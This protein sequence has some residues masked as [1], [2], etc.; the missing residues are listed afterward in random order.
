MTGERARSAEP[1]RALYVHVPFCLSVCPYC[2]FVVHTGRTARGPTSAVDAFVAAAVAEVRLRAEGVRGRFGTLGPLRSVYLGGG[3]PS[4]LAPAQVASLLAA[5]QE[6][7]GLASDAEI[8]LEA[9]PGPADRGDLVGFRAAGVNRLSIGA[10][11]FQASEL[12]RLGRRHAPEDVANTVRHARRAGFDDV[13][14]DLLYDVPGQTLDSWR[15]SLGRALALEPQHISA[16]A[17]ALDDPQAEGLTG[18]D[19][20]HLPIRRGARRWRRHAGAEQ[21]DDR[22]AACYELLDTMLTDVG[23]C[24]YEIS[25]WS[26]PGRQSRHN[27]VYW[28]GGAYEGVGPGAHAFDGHLTRRWNAARLDAYLAALLPADGSPTVLPPGGSVSADGQSAAA[29]QVILA[30]RTR[31]GLSALTARL[32][33]FAPPLAWGRSMGLLE[34]GEDRASLRLTLRGRLLAGELFWRLLP[35]DPSA[36]RVA[37]QMDLSA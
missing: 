24:W 29:E 5:A 15:R 21:D 33:A 37:D 11:S 20:D 26:S 9:N 17:L 25:N 14:L 35:T 28:Q 34:E 31:A 1:P 7:F 13:S 23:L 30:L 3:T 8:T 12:R 6:G 18:V 4:L 2:D 22:A 36:A 27:L 19:G 10:Q 32:P 16:Y